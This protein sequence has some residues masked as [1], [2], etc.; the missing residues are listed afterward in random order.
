MMTVLHTLGASLAPA[1]SQCP[2]Q[3]V[4]HE[5]Q[6]P[7]TAAPIPPTRPTLGEQSTWTSY[8]EDN[9]CLYMR[10]CMNEYFLRRPSKWGQRLLLNH[11]AK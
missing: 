3:R 2:A 1:F 9:A 11:G 8:E 5:A 10:R 7:A 6:H 4:R